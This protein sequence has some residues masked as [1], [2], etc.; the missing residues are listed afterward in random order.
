MFV[1][2]NLS[3]LRQ[4]ILTMRQRD[5]RPIALVPTMGALHDGHLSLV[6]SAIEDGC[7]CIATIFINPTQFAAHEDMNRYPVRLETDLSVLEG[8]GIQGVW[9]PSVQTM[10]PGD[11]LTRVQVRGS[12]TSMW[13][14]AHRPHFFTGV[15]TV[16]TKLL[17]G[18]MP[19]RAYFGEKDFQQLKVVK[20]LC[21]DLLLP[22]QI[23]G[24]PTIREPDGLA[25]SSR[26]AYLSN[27]ERM[28]APEL[29]KTMQ[30]VSTDI[31][32]GRPIAQAQSDGY[33]RL[34]QTG[35]NSVGYFSAVRSDDLSTLP[36]FNPEIDSRL[37][38][39]ANLG[40]TRLIDNISI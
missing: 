29:Y 39:A 8:L 31:R 21:H 20:A 30:M 16:V 11:D 12:L 5:P 36:T 17:I 13:E 23:I 27:E 3:A 9:T 24:C 6:R 7:Q 40:H 28:Q 25:M 32:A 2:E 33:H 38:A 19:D 22:M 1:H 18:T 34:L 14:G 35:F 15:A 4:D 37:I 10:Y 26:N